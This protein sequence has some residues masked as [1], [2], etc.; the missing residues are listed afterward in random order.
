MFGLVPVVGEVSTE[1][2]G[3]KGRQLFENPLPTP[4]SLD[5]M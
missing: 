4:H 3:T 1:A 2:R 5:T